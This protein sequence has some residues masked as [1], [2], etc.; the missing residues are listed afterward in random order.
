MPVDRSVV[1]SCY[2]VVAGRVTVSDSSELP[3]GSDLLLLLPILGPRV[4]LGVA[5]VP[6][7][8]GEG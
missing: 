6:P 7:R 1:S 3:C 5:V 4:E 8:G 2:V